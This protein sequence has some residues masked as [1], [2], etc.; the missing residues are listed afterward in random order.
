MP[1]CWEGPVFSLRVGKFPA[2]VA[3]KVFYMLLVRISINIIY[4]FGVLMVSQRAFNF[5]H[6]IKIKK[7]FILKFLSVF[8]T[9]CVNSTLTLT[10]DL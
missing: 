10:A 9:T 7:I 6:I 8:L 1:H 5:T 2:M 4:I 3:L